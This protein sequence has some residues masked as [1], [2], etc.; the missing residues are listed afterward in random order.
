MFVE[1]TFSHEKKKQKKGN[2]GK[3]S[4]FFRKFSENRMVI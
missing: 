3:N 2:S 1:R 4:I